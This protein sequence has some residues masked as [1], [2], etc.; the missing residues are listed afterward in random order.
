M[1]LQNYHMGNYCYSNF[2]KK[3][4]C[5]C[6]KKQAQFDLHMCA[7][8]GVRALECERWSATVGVR[9]LECDR[10]SASVGVQA[11]ECDRWSVSVAV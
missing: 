1:A 10:W 7:S 3:H 8:V 4:L 11:L 9:A 5:T 6:D 2:S